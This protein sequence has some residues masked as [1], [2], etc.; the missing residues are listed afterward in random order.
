MTTFNASKTFAPPNPKLTECVECVECENSVLKRN[1]R[2]FIYGDCICDDCAE[3]E[4][5]SGQIYN[6][7]NIC[8]TI[9]SGEHESRVDDD[10]Y[11]MVSRYRDSEF[12]DG[13]VCPVCLP[14]FMEKNEY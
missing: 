4:D 11:E 10:Y 6:L 12:H 13:D 8:N 1:S 5:D 9:Y 14:E 7:C 3:K 2:P